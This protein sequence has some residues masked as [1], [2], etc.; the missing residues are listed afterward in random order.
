MQDVALHDTGDRSQPRLRILPER[1]EPHLSAI[2]AEHD[3]TEKAADS[4]TEGSVQPG[5]RARQ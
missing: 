1:R 3:V 4:R 2:Q 5:L